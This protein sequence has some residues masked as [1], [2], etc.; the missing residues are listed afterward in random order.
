ML[1]RLQT[2]WYSVS[3]LPS[4]IIG[5][6]AV[7]AKNIKV[8]YNN[9]AI[10]IIWVDLG[11]LIYR[12]VVVCKH[13]IQMRPFG[14]GCFCYIPSLMTVRLYEINVGVFLDIKSEWMTFHLNK[15]PDVRESKLH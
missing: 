14:R 6:F 3:L 4:V 10:N 15:A 12:G 1:E 8:E 9:I 2:K 5:S 13:Q 11:F 7:D